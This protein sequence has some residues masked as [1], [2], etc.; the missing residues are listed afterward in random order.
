MTDIQKKR[1][2]WTGPIVRMYQGRAVKEMYI[3]VNWMEVEEEEKEED[4][5]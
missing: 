3:R 5:D 1:L 2:E 4:L